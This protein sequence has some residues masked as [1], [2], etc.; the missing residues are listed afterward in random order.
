MNEIM[1]YHYNTDLTGAG[2][3]GENDVSVIREWNTQYTQ[4]WLDSFSNFLD[5]EYLILTPYPICPYFLVEL[6]TTE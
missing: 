1:V 2:I 3:V 5:A 4:G 6:N